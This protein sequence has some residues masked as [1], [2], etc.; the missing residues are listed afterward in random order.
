MIVLKSGME[1]ERRS[2]GIFE[3]VDERPS[4]PLTL[5]RDG[6]AL[7]FEIRAALLVL[8][9]GHRAFRGVERSTRA[10]REPASGVHS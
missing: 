5:G 6:E 2:P 4:S 3:R 7:S 1:R 9:R 10:T 8:V